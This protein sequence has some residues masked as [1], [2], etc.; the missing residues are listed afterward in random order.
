MR[1]S[2]IS[3]F[4]SHWHHIFE[5][6]IFSPQEFYQKLEGVLKEMRVP[7]VSLSRKLYNQGGFLSHKREYLR[8]E[9]REFVFDVC[10]APFGKGY[11]VSWW[12]GET[13]PASDLFA[14]LP[15]LGRLF[16]KHTKTFYE[17]D[18]EIMFQEIVKRCV[19]ETIE[20]LTDSKGLRKLEE[21]EWQPHNQVYKM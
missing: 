13:S 6:T 12:L 9:Y 8:V 1:V 15:I 20:T 4:N 5:E 16:K 19:R 18:T 14:S 11:F 7:S 10:A 17:I 3:K 2:M 21:A